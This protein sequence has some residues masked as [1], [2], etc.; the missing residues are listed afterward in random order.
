MRALVTGGAGFIGSTLVDR[1]LADGHEVVVVD[2]LSSGADAN[3]DAARQAGDRLVVH[4]KDIRDPATSEIV[5][6]SGAEV[7]YHLAAQ[8]DV[9]VSVAQPALDASINVIGLLRVLEGA[10]EGA[11]RKVVFAS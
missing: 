3:L 9:R 6:A 5:A 1:L 4:V 7:V 11:V 10:R 2:D 8:A